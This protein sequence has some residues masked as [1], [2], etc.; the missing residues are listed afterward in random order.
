M[1]PWFLHQMKQVSD[2]LKSMESATMES[3]DEHALRSAKRMGISDD[4]LA[5]VL[6]TESTKV[7]ELHCKK[8]GVKLPFSSVVDTCAAEFESLTPYMYSCYDEE[9]EAA[10][11]SKKKVIILGSGPEPHRAG[12]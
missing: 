6:N 10:P 11:T 8:L 5:V 1:D 4:R 9:D 3:V 7:G 2:E 12:H